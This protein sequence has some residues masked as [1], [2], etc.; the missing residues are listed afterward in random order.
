MKLG[1]VQYRGVVAGNRVF[2]HLLNL[3][4]QCA[5]QIDY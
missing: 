2:M 1:S 5:T 3:Q 4:I